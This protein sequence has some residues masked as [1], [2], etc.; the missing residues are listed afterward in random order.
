MVDVFISY[1]RVD[2]PRIGRLADALQA[3]GYSVWWDHEIAGG[4]AFAS[5]IERALNEAKAVVVAW[6]VG[7]IQS[8]WV[9]DE[10][11]I[12]KDA[13]KLVPIQ[14]D[15]TR[16]PLGFR[17]YQVVDFSAWKGADDPLPIQVL[18][19]SIARY[20]RRGA[21]LASAE[22]LEHILPSVQRDAIAVLP[23]ENLSGDP[24]Q[25]YLV[26]GMQ[27]AL[28]TDL[29]KIGSLKVISRT[30]TRRYAGSA[31]SLREIAA[32]LG[33]SRIIEG[34]VFR[35]GD[36]VRMTVQLI[37]ARSDTHLW[38]GT[39]DRE[40]TN[41]LTLQREVARAIVDEMRAVL[42]PAEEARLATAPRVHPEAYEAYLKGMYHWYKL[43]PNDLQSALRYFDAAL[44]ADAD[45]A[46]AHA[47]TAA[48]WTG[49]QQ[50]GAV[51]TT[52]A[53]PK[54][55]SAVDRALHLDPN[56]A[57]A[58]FTL[59]T[60]YT[61]AAWEWDKA[62]PC[63]RRAIELN[64]SF[65]DAHAFFA[66]YLNII[67]RFDEAEAQ[68]ER[69][70]SL[71]PFNPLVRALYVVCLM[72]TQ[73]YDEAIAQARTVLNTA[74]DHWLAF[75]VLRVIH[76][77]RGMW[78]DALDATRSLFVTLD[79]PAVVDALARGSNQGGYRQAM[80]LAADTLAIR[81]ETSFV[82]PT[83]IATLYGMADEVD[84][85]V[86]WLEKAFTVRDPNLPYMKYLPLFPA[87]VMND[88]RTVAILE[89]LRYPPSR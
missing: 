63:F 59:G 68:I 85:S 23:L 21:P 58:H 83:R 47:G 81:A 19:Q 6:S 89:A 41:I 3:A 87:S 15:A 42:T 10:A 13:G 86:D 44:A 39:F 77:N 37:D 36:A 49:L 82:L 72:F 38:A 51:P 48:V 67:G 5:E 8:D 31:Q 60:Y 1:A 52:V 45:Y 79:N 20:V 46:P 28:I 18:S 78:T 61:W 55:K 4:T 29:S 50:M 57:Q 69:A 9:M 65:P 54:I 88:P 53:G 11:T 34:S 7:A 33:A 73:R 64:A 25:Q 12:A 74:P 71:D 26:D 75:E 32:E 43:T 56:L 14:L 2:R 17:Q 40:M 76:H 62:E 66:H 27:E 22:R 24:A 84:K 35:A 70:L 30:S 80:R 16:P